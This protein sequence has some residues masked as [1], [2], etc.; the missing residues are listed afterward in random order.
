MIYEHRTY[1]ILPGKMPEFTETFGNMLVP[2]FEKYGAK[3]IGVWQTVIG[4]NDEFT[5]ILGFDGLA[6]QEKFWRNFRQ[7]EQYKKYRQ[8][9]P[10]VSYVVSKILQPTPYSSL[11]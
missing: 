10:P 2:L 9:A 11:K 7:D 3:L 5:Y 6:N 8:G 4:Q 1:H